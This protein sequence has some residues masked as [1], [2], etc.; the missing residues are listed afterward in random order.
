MPTTKRKPYW[1]LFKSTDSDVLSECNAPTS[2]GMATWAL[3]GAIKY[4]PPSLCN[5]SEF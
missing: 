5:N 4:G 3:A 2:Y 1:T